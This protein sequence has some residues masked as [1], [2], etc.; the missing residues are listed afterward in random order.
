MCVD[1]F[2][3][4]GGDNVELVGGIGGLLVVMWLDVGFERV[5]KFKFRKN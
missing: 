2:D 3:V 1:F 4:F 5:F